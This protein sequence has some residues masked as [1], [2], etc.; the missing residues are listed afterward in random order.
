[1]KNPRV[2]LVGER[3]NHTTNLRWNVLARE[4]P[5]KWLEVSR[6]AGAYC[7]GLTR[8]RALNKNLLRLGLRPQRDGVLDEPYFTEAI[9]LLPPSPIVG[10]WDAEHAEYVARELNE[11]RIVGVN[12]FCK[13]GVFGHWNTD[14]I[15]L[16]GRKVE[17]AFLRAPCQFFRP[18]LTP[19]MQT[20]LVTLPHPS[21]V[22][23]FWNDSDEVEKG[24]FLLYS[25]WEEWRAAHTEQ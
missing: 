18:I 19:D 14:I 1:M 20:I 24:R 23:R 10:A 9:N 13:D 11:L 2:L 3:W 5:R 4:N 7:T 6:R 15:L 17:H 25:L 12:S 22:N 21:G 8:H 16:L